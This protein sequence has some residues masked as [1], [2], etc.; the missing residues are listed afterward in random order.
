[1]TKTPHHPLQINK[2]FVRILRMENEYDMYQGS[3]LHAYCRL[4]GENKTLNLIN[5]NNDIDIYTCDIMGNSIL[6]LACYYGYSLLVEKLCTY[7]ELIEKKNRYNMTPLHIA[8][9]R[10][11]P[12]ISLYLINKGAKITEI[13]TTGNTV[14]HLSVLSKNME[15][16]ALK[17]IDNINENNNNILGM[18]GERNT[19]ALHIACFNKLTNVAIKILNLIQ[20]EDLSKIDMYFRT[21]LHIACYNGLES[22]IPLILDK[23]DKKT[24]EQEDINFYT[25]YHLACQNGHENIAITIVESQK[26]DVDLIDINGNTLLHIACI[27]KLVNLANILISKMSSIDIPNKYSRTPLHIACYKKM[28]EL[29]SCMVLLGCSNFQDID[30]KTPLM[31]CKKN[32][33]NDVA[34]LISKRHST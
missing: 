5:N 24:I 12:D 2:Y 11:L 7:N 10:Q 14:L 21:P 29:A 33:M 19:T 20:P 8:C 31:I 22:L 15:N 13:S 26:M 16:V 9:W 4:Y 23:T 18:S 28:N 1:M 30:G 17:I 6:H 34:N 3:L 27:N 32:K 25:P